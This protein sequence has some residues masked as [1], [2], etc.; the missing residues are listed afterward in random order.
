MHT[1]WSVHPSYFPILNV[2][3]LL[4]IFPSNYAVPTLTVTLTANTTHL[5]NVAPYNTFLLTCT[6]TSSV[7]R[8]G[9]VALPKRFQWL[10]RYV[11]PDAIG[12]TQLS[13]NITI[14][15]QDGDNLNQP[16][17]SSMLTVTEDIPQDYRYRCRVDLDLP[18]DNISTLADVY[19]ITVTSKYFLRMCAVLHLCKCMMYKL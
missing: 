6:A 2:L 16:T 12:L 3:T 18:A 9:N 1:F 8:V 11:P 4:V 7:E 15:I 13:R 5:P 14:Q 10:R 17:S 19:P